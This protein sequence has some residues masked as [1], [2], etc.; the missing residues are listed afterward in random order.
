MDALEQLNITRYEGFKRGL[1]VLATGM[2]KTF[3]AA[4]DAKQMQAQRVLFVAHREE[5]LLQAQSAFNTVLPEKSSGLFKADRKDIDADFM[6]EYFRSKGVRAAAVYSNSTLGR[7]EALTQLENQQLDVLFS[8]DLFNEGT[9]IPSL[10]TLLMIRPTE[11]KIIFLQQLGRGLRRS[12]A[13]QKQHVVVLDFLGNHQSFLNNPA[14]LLGYHDSQTALNKALRSQG[15]PIELA[16]GCYVNFDPRLLDFWQQLKRRIGASAQE[17][18]QQLT[19]EL[20]H[21]PTATEF[22]HAGYS[23]QKVRQQHGSWLGLLA[24]QEGAEY[25]A[26]LKAHGEFFL[27]AVE[28]TRLNKSFKAYLYQAFVELGGVRNAV[29]VDAVAQRSRELL[30]HRPDRLAVELP[31]SVRR[32]ASDSRAWINYWRKNPIHYSCQQDKRSP[33][34]W[35]AEENGVFTLNFTVEE[36]LQE[37]IGRASW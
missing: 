30:E 2:G 3:L 16:A 31:A 28:T 32:V 8:V 13:T 27:D 7:Q 37:Q 5:I 1:I 34:A 26:L 11:S 19:L 15:E 35:F 6:A 24:V 4:F 20:G 12:E 10:D 29:S 22:F 18:Y 23:L 21:R 33:Q 9:D 36:A 25:S 17:D 14:A